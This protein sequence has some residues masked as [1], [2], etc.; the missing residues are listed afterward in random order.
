M[1]PVLFSAIIIANHSLGFFFFFSSCSY[2]LYILN[3]SILLCRAFSAF[4]VVVLPVA[5]HHMPPPIP[6]PG[7]LS[8]NLLLSYVALM[9]VL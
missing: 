6:L 5:S 1:H 8:F 2:I 3:V 7:F 9:I 4:V